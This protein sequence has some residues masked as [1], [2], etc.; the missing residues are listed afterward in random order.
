[1]LRDTTIADVHGGGTECSIE[2]IVLEDTENVGFSIFDDG[3]DPLVL[4]KSE[5]RDAIADM[6]NDHEPLPNTE[7]QGSNNKNSISQVVEYVGKFIF[8]ST[9][10]SELNGNPFLS[11]DRLTCIRNSIYFN[12]AED[13]LSAAS[14]QNS[15]LLG[16]GS[17]CSVFFVSR[18]DV[19]TSSSINATRKRNRGGSVRKGS[20]TNI[21]SSCDS[22]SW[23]IGRVQKIRRKAGTKWGI[24]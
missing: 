13:Y 1:M 7:G 24:S 17:D 5:R 18:G 19:G 20:P 12:N 4:A 9:L 23:W 10:V 8:K 11:K 6:L 3:V 16:L 15:Y 14:S 2:D 21:S 22:G